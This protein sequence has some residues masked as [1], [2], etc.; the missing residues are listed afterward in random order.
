[1]KPGQN[2]KNLLKCLK[3]D[4]CLPDYIRI[5]RA[6]RLPKPYRMRD[7]GHP[8]YII[9]KLPF[10]KDNETILHQAR[11]RCEQSPFKLKGVLTAAREKELVSF[12]SFNKLVEISKPSNKRNTYVYDVANGCVK[13]VHIKNFNDELDITN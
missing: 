6:H 5:E 9:V 11:S 7:K 2:V 4:M 10:H 13:V 3:Q 12:L 8:R 1:M